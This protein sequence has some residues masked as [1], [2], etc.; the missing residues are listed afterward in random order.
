[1]F[2][3]G[4]NFGRTAG[5]PF[6]TTSYDYDAPIDEYGLIR[7]PKYGHLRELHR[8]IKLCQEAIVSSDPRVISLGSSQEASI[9]SDGKGKCAA[10]LANL[11][12]KSAARVVFNNRHHKL[13]PWSVSI[14]PDCNNVVFNTAKVG[15]Q[16]SKVKMSQSNSRL[17]S[18]ETYHEDLAA[19]EDS[20]AF[21]SVGL[22][23]QINVTKDN[24][25]YLWYITS[26]DISSSESFLRGG[27]KPT[28]IIHSR[29]HAVHVFINRKFSGSAYGS[30]EGMRFTFNGP[31][32][33]HAGKNEIALLS[34]AMGLPVSFCQ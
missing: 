32:E 18:W 15:T 1:M 14:L 2:H 7:Q 12:T 23:D 10:F 5:G 22:L 3:G 33:L 24:S 31:V 21:T 30:R 28:L 25:D 20:S 4:T 16:T 17:H 6:V 13:P 11:D 29:G 8:A 27:K 9:F 19:L 34:L 26:V